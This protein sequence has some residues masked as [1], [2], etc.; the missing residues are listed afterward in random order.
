M[1]GKGYGTGGRRHGRRDR[2]RLW[3]ASAGA[4]AWQGAQVERLAQEAEW[5][6]RYA[7]I[8]SVGLRKIIKK[9]DKRCANRLGYDFLQ[10]R[11]RWGRS[12]AGGGHEVLPAHAP[13]RWLQ[14]RCLQARMPAR[15]ACAWSRSQ[16]SIAVPAGALKV[17]EVGS[18]D[19]AMHDEFGRSPPNPQAAC[20]AQGLQLK[21]RNC[22]PNVSS[23]LLLCCFPRRWR[24]CP[25]AETAV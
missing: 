17:L 20:P 4:Q 11:A 24:L 14:G 7:A 15:G 16:A 19:N 22:S 13:M 3:P 2:W 23:S 25:W 9:H 21:P 5:C 18:A 12:E 8:N 10:A 6:R 1:R